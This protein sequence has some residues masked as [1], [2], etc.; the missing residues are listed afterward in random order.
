[1]MLRRLTL[2]L[3][4]TALQNGL[5][6]GVLISLL[7]LAGWSSG[8]F[9]QA[10]LRLT[11]V[12]FIPRSASNQIVIVALDDPSHERFGR[13]VAGWPRSIYTDLVDFLAAAEAR[14]V[15]FDVLFS[16]PTGYDFGLANAIRSARQQPART[17]FVMPAVGTNVTV[18]DEANRAVG[19][20]GVI[21]PREL[22]VEVV[23]YVGFVNAFVDVDSMIRRQ[24]SRV[25]SNGE[26][27]ISLALAT[28]LA[29]LRIP[30]LAVEQTVV[31]EGNKL[32]VAAQRI[33]ID[34]RGFWRQNYFGP[35]SRGTNVTFPTYSI[36]DILDGNVSREAF[37]DKVVMVGLINTTA[38]TDLYAVPISQSGELMAGVEIQAN[39]VESL[40]RGEIP[41]EQSPLEQVLMITGLTLFASMIYAHF[42][43]YW[44]IPA[45][46]MLVVALL[47]VA[48]ARFSTDL[49]IINLLYAL[50][51]LALPFVAHLIVDVIS[52][53]NRRRKA[54]FLLKSVF[55]ISQ[56]RMALDGVLPSVAADLRRVLKAAAGGIWLREAAN[57]IPTLRHQWGAEEAVQRLEAS[58]RQAL[59]EKRLVY[60]ATSAAV[61]VIWQKR[62]IGV[63]AV[64]MIHRGLPRNNDLRLFS[65]LADEV[66]PSLENAML[67]T[68]T[69]E[70]NALLEAILA[71]SPAGVALLDDELRLQRMNPAAV[72]MMGNTGEPLEGSPI[73]KWFE[74]SQLEPERQ[75]ALAHD[76]ANAH[77][78]RHE[79]KIGKKVYNLDAAQLATGNWVV[80]LHDVSS[81]AELSRLK[82]QMV[83]MT[84]H[85][86][87]KPLSRI[88]GYGSLLLD[89]QD[90]E[91][92][93]VQQQQYLQRIMQAGEEMLQIIDNILN[94][95]QLRSSTI[96]NQP[97][98]LE[99]L[100]R[101][102]VERFEPDV[103]NKAQTL[104]ADIKTPLPP[105][106]GDPLLLVQA[107]NNLVENAVKYTPS[108][109]SIV[110]R[111][112]PL[113]RSV[114][115][116]IED[117]GFGISES[118]QKRLF[119]EFYRV[120][121]R[122]TAHISGTGLGL[123]LAKSIV[124]AH[125]GRIWLK[126]QEGVGTTFYIELPSQQETPV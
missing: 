114:R 40:L 69:Q 41:H 37:R 91:D 100:V 47:V 97:L 16:E 32:Q 88:V 7:L 73:S 125:T 81:L 96:R 119:E 109:G 33:P 124:E 52:E 74:D 1:M 107:L 89:Q 126:S 35:P 51:A 85:D 4:Q 92:L 68:Q 21:H 49:E 43:W 117:T 8:L 5:L 84:S 93:N 110:T 18:L 25:M 61:P 86:L 15:T 78:F 104:T 70:Q 56:Q 55:E 77:N 9:S 11:D 83:R 67:Y 23:D 38:A 59:S 111:L 17:R 121:T 101:Q 31:L 71:G 95:E 46:V 10:Q 14:V 20:S 75:Q 98:N 63:F 22:F 12:Y 19:F 106:V 103:K 123:S 90:G 66:A 39:A 120:R 36:V 80:I 76:F 6:T 60:D 87:K 65:A 2:R 116:E 54:E 34:T 64:E 58:A 24:I 122:E 118:A 94:L 27:G 105:V 102:V 45:L 112:Y 79:I 82:T 62:V 29:Y 26:N 30:A 57:D 3:N 113:E 50:G 28:Y 42:R 48:L 13:S 108:S 99:S 44:T 115:I 72:Q 53:I